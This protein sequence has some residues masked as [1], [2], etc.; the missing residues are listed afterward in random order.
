M[1]YSNRFIYHTLQPNHMKAIRF[2][3]LSLVALM[4]FSILASISGLIPENENFENELI[5]EPTKMEATSPGHPVF[6]EYVGAYWCGPC[7]AASNN[8]HSL[9]GT[10]GGGGSQAEDFTYISFWESA[11]TGWPAD[12]PINRRAHINPR[13]YPTV[14]YGDATSSSSYHTNSNNAA[15]FYESGGFDE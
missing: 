6:A 2:T 14:V 8:L 5:E 3:A 11:A 13:A 10:N 7:K 15:S 12:S 1:Q 4:L 9:Y